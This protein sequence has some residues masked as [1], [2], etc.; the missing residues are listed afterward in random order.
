[1]KKLTSEEIIDSLKLFLTNRDMAK[2]SDNSSDDYY[3]PE[4]FGVAY[5]QEK[6]G[7]IL[8]QAI[9]QI[10]EEKNEQI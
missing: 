8:E 3:E 10:I 1:M 9:K 7:Y 4:G 2:E 6:Q 5:C